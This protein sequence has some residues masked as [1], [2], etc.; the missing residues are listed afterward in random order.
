[1]FSRID[2]MLG[3]K[4]SLKKFKKTEIISNIFSDY[5]AMKLEINQKKKTEKYTKTW[6]LN[7]MSVNNEWVN[8]EIKEE[9][10]RYFERNENENTTI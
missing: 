9:I 10:K 5:N 1:M 7:N 4:T 3:R 6:N 2:N 8:D